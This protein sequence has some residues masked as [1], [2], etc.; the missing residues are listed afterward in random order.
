[1]ISLIK[2]NR[3]LSQKNRIVST[4]QRN[5]W[6]LL[7]RVIVKKEGQNEINVPKGTEIDTVSF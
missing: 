4:P 7:Y 3:V 5:I 1:M 6:G 2:M